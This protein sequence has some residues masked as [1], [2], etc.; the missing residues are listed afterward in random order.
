M[1]KETHSDVPIEHLNNTVT[2]PVLRTDVTL[3]DDDLSEEAKAQFSFHTEI[4]H[5]F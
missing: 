1:E 5:A 3:C 4:L 2:Q